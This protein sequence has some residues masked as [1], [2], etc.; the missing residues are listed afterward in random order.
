M[1]KVSRLVGGRFVD[2]GRNVLTG[3]DCW[4]LVMEVYKMC[5]TKVPDFAVGA[6]DFAVINALM[7][8]AVGSGDWEE[9]V[10]PVDND[11]PLVVL[12]R[13]HPGLITHAGVYIGG[14][15]IIHTMKMT[16]I[17]LSR[18]DSLQS[19]ITGYY[20]YVDSN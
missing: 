12:M 4:G 17:I 6:F 13:M 8:E 9:V 3:L 16:G 14:N 2:G 5:G 18:M 20:R 7:D 1:V 10:K 11:A 19:R 15:R